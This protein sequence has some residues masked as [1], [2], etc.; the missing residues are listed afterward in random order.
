MTIQSLNIAKE[1][2]LSPYNLDDTQLMTLMN[3]LRSYKIDAADLYLQSLHHES[4]KL[5]NG[6][7]KSGGF[8]IEQGAGIRAISGEKTGF[9]YS[10]TLDFKALM[11]AAQAARSI[12][13]QQNLVKRV[14]ISA[15]GTRKPLY[16]SESPLLSLADA[17]KLEL[18]TPLDS[19]ARSI[20]PHVVQV[21]AGLQAQHEIILL[22]CHDGKILADMRPMI[23]MQVSVIVE[24]AGKREQGYAVKMTRADYK[25]L[26]EKHIPQE[27][28]ERAV[29]QALVNLEAEPAP[30]GTMPVVLG[31]G[32]PGVLI[33]EA[34]G[35]GLEGDFNRKGSSAFS[36]KLGQQVASPCCTIVDNGTLAEHSGSL[37]MDDEGTPTQNTTLIEKGLLKQ[38]MQDNLNAR[39]MNMQSTGNGR[40]ESYR[41]LPMPRMTNTYILPGADDPE[42]IIAS[43]ER[44]LYAVD[45]SGGQV[46]IT[47]GKFVFST[48]R[49]YLIEKGKI[50]RPVTGAT[51]IGNGPDVLMRVSAVG[52]DLKIAQDG[53]C[54]KAGQ[55]V[56]VSV[57]QPTLRIDSLTVGGTSQ[58][59]E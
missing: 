35:H 36:N 54:G 12:A 56:P 39:L 3:Y 59:N 24:H 11:A 47:S 38:Y 25:H 2:L 40:R 17:V 42:A 48:S 53:W 29:N 27:L 14:A 19:M 31:P 6:I 51:L 44:G 28:V 18:L 10:Q 49:A 1:S 37:N 20:S 13:R 52:H 50:T 21:N 33:H 5:E 41:H 4:W 9:A 45:F 16:L 58:S 30:A 57:G 43:V 34:V 8:N 15:P 32:A 26:M 55:T 46:D 22:V 23:S 7:L